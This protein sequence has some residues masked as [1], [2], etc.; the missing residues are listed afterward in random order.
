MEE[1]K[2]V[3]ENKAVTPQNKKGGKKW[4]V[5]IGA[6][7]VVILIAVMSILYLN[8]RPQSQAGAKEIILTVVHADETSKEFDIHTDEEYLQGALQQ[9]GLIEGTEGEYGLYVLTVDGETVDETK[10]QWWCL[11]KGGE[12][13]MLGVGET[14]IADGE[15]YEFTFT[16]GW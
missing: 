12:A 3:T 4:P 10:E 8:S 15:Q 2:T 1:N 9:E 14:L 6:A 13:H 5:I 11:T 7:V 16:T